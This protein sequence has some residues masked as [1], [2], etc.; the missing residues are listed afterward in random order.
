MSQRERLPNRR[1]HEVLNFEHNGF[2]YVAGMGR[3][4]DGRLAEVFLDC[5]KGGTAVDVSAR[6]SAVV[7]SI[8]LQH[9]VAP[10]T[11]RHAILR[12]ADGSAAGPLGELLDMIA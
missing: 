5:S 8:A 12:N 10:Q 4:A 1:G 6:D 11:L 2:R 3:F 9:G 7:A